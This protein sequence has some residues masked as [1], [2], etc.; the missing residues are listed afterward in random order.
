MNNKK[1]YSSWNHFPIQYGKIDEFHNIDK[2]SDYIVKNTSDCIPVGNFRSYGD[3]V[4]NNKMVK[5]FGSKKVILN[6]S[7][8]IAIVSSNILIGDLIKETMPHGFFPPV[9]PGTKYVSIGGAIAADIH[10]KN[11]HLKG[12]FCEHLIWVEIMVSDGSI[13]RCSKTINRDLF[14]MTCGGMGLTGIIIKAAI[15]MQ[16]I[17]SNSIKQIK[18]VAKNLSDLF[19]LFMDNKNKEYSVAWIDCTA[20]GNSLGRGII[21][22]G[23]FSKKKDIKAKRLATN[24]QIFGIPFYFPKFF[25]NRFTI[26]FFNAMYFFFSAI[27]DKQESVIDYD[28]Y[29]FP[30]DKISNWNRLYGISGFLQYQFVLPLETSLKGLKIIL[31]LIANSGQASPIT[32][33][34]LLGPENKNFLSFPMEGYTLAVDFKNHPSVFPLLEKL[35]MIVNQNGGRIYLAKDARISIE[36]FQKNYKNVKYFREYRKLE[37]MYNKFTFNSKQSY[38]LGL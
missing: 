8:K 3:C 23:E 9:V 6:K 5:Y 12:S 36:N 14:Q 10:G 31:T 1:Y 4:L 15:K 20:T 16:R 35:D 28:N 18:Y 33:L 7:K 27:K 34:K 22:L 38:R 17:N 25:M 19:Q 37:K 30:L 26:R 21:L 24:S 11:H 2:L 32:V 13:I 29:F